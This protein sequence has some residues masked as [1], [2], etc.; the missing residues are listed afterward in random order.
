MGQ[1]PSAAERAAKRRLWPVRLFK[2]GAEPPDDLSAMTTP[3]E[4]LAM[5]WP[6]ALEAWTLAGLPLPGYA[7]AETPVSL[8]R[9]SP[10]GEV[11][12]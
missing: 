7:R 12:R 1:T 10:P 5:M 8:R 6:L 2:L 11:V 9:L 3:E 4:R